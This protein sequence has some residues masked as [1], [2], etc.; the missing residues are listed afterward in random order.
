MGIRNTKILF[1]KI[2]YTL[3]VY[4]GNTVDSYL[5]GLSILFLSEQLTFLYVSFF[6]SLVCLQLI[7]LV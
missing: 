3:L 2:M 7:L 6:Q 1:N 5:D 4:H